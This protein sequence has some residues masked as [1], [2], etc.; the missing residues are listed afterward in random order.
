MAEKDCIR[1]SLTNHEIVSA[2]I[3]EAK[4]ITTILAMA[5]TP[6]ADHPAFELLSSALDGVT[7]LLEDADNLMTDIQIERA[8]ENK[9][10]Y[11]EASSALCGVAQAR[12]RRTAVAVLNKYGAENLAYVARDKLAA[13]TAECNK[14]RAAGA[15]A[16]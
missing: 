4:A 13:F 16:H 11:E 12:G 9:K 6:G 5:T 8:Q 2:R 7:S 14:L 10:T 1:D 3:A 15:A